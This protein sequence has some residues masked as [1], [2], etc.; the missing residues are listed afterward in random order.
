M[1]HDIPSPPAMTGVEFRAA[2]ESLFGGYGS[3]RAFARY[4]GIHE[5]S[6]RRYVGGNRDIPSAVAL[7]VAHMLDR[8]GRGLDPFL[9]GNPAMGK[10]PVKDGPPTYADLYK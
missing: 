7:L 2:I 4:S 6:V 1:R 5:T 9:D 3:Q 10:V 8:Q